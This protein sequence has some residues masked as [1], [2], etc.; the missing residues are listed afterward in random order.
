MK[1]RVG[2]GFD[3]HQLV[4]GREL[5]L[6]G[7]KFEHE[8]GLLGHSDAD[9]LV[10]AIM[11]ALLGAAALGDIGKHFPDTDPTYKGAVEKVRLATTSEELV[12][13]SYN[14]YS[15]LSQLEDSLG[16]I[17]EIRTQTLAGNEDCAELLDSIKHYS[18]LYSELLAEREMQFYIENTPN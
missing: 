14:L 6:G 15:E 13:I 3:V 4:P 16:T 9:V 7:I 10:H 11:D 17:E 5:W 18:E 8:L 2:F 12:T 1:I